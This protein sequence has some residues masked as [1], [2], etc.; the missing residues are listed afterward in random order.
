MILKNVLKFIEVRNIFLFDIFR[1][2]LV[3]RVGIDAI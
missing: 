3:G 1:N 2:I